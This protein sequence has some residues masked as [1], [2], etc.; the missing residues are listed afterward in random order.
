MKGIFCKRGFTTN[1]EYRQHI[2]KRIMI[3]AGLLAAGVIAFLI[4]AFAG[5]SPVLSGNAKMAGFYRGFGTGVV[6]AALV[7][8]IKHLR[9]LKN[10]E[11]MK[12]YWI[13]NEDER[14]QQLMTKALQAGLWVLLIGIYM[15]M[16]IGGLWYPEITTA[17]A[18]LVTLFL[19]AYAVSYLILSKR[20]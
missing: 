12:K 2:K 13:A 18:M 11:E 6:A 7:L 8:L 16:L 14:N 4:P 3:F 1:E 10:E 20:M 17:L 15:T 5:D 19:G 9:I